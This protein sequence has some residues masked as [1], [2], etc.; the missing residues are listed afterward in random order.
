MPKNS[1][2]KQNHKPWCFSTYFAEG[3]PYSVIR[4]L[5]SI[6]FTD[7]GMKE[8][9][10][11]YF[12]FLGI[13]WN[14]KFLWAPFLDLY[15][16]KRGW[17]IVLQGLIA[18]LTAGLAG[19][20]FLAP[21]MA[22]PLRVIEA[23][24]I[25]LV[26]LAF[27]SATNDIAIDGY[28][29]EAIPDK[30]EQAALT[31]FRV[32]AWRLALIAVK[33]GLVAIAAFV[34]A[35]SGNHDVYRPWA[36]A[37]A[38]AALTMAAL[39]VIHILTLPRVESGIHAFKTPKEIAAEFAEAFSTYLETTPVKLLRAVVTTTALALLYAFTLMPI[40]IKDS[41]ALTS[42]WYVLIPI[43]CAAA[44][45]GHLR[46][47]IALSLLFIIFYKVGDEVLF[48]MGSTFLMRELLVTKAHMAWLAGIV[49]AIGSIIGTTIGGL[50]IKKV[51]FKK[52]IWPLTILMNFN[53]WAYIWLAH[54][55]PTAKTASGLAIIA[56]VHFYEQLAAGLGNASLIVFILRT[57]KPEF[58]ASHYAV[59]SA[60]MSL[61][62][63]FFGGFGGVIVEQMGYLNMF[64]LAFGLSIPSM[65]L[66][67]TL[68]LEDDAPI[69]G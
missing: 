33:S 37:F 29:I 11:G 30:T 50:W 67:F 51:G 54:A 3:F 12:N 20:C 4:V 10:I 69:K 39:T 25:M 63:T 13:P 16:T 18:I 8:R 35:Q 7:I 66:I 22:D 40:L 60:I 59:G 46:K 65:L 32:F 5:S 24:A 28:Y 38:V 42:L 55:H 68:K 45:L 21:H 43:I 31:G 17:M 53:I 47:N 19:S 9:Y 61:F 49:G 41:A 52:A 62:S 64:L 6:F 34:A 15:G 36:V 56:A 23:S 48:S 26:I 1:S 44:F 14:F 27:L 57:C 58:K 2:S